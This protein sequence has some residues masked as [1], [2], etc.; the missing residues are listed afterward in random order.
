MTA[1]VASALAPGMHGCTFGGGPVAATAGAVGARARRASPAFLARV[2]RR[3]RD[4][5][6]GARRRSSR[7]HRVAR[8]GARP[9]PAARGRARARRAVRRRRRWSRAARE[10]G[11]LLVR[12]GERAVRLLPPLTVTHG[13]DRRG[14]R[15]P[16]PRAHRARSQNEETRREAKHRASARCSPT[17]AGSTPAS[18]CHWLKEHYGCEVVCYCSRRRPGRTSS[19]ASRR[20]RAR[21]APTRSWSRTC[22]CRSSR[23]FCFPALRAG[24]VYEGTLP[25]RHLARAA[26]DR[27]APGA[28]ARERI[29]A[30]ALAHGCTGK[31]NDQVRFELTYMAL[32]PELT[33]DRAVARVGHRLARGR[34][35]LRREARHR[36]CRRRRATCTRAT[37]NLWHLSHE[38]GP[39]EDP[40]DARARVDVPAHRRARRSARRRPRRVTI[41]FEARPAG[42]AR[43][44][45]ALGPV[46]LRRR[47]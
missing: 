32:A 44:A 36:R 31:G 11:L 25:A 39:L 35:R 5:A 13:R 46:A 37:R 7:A 45:S 4:A 17:R 27:R 42:D 33:G 8:R 3:G 34:A 41:G 21:S 2:R 19:T 20:A 38:G 23:D 40:A 47:R 9:R 22:A 16:R 24:A 14:A 1:D 43:T 18:S 26:A 12:G 10:H 28:R 30:D 15:A 6:R 29:G